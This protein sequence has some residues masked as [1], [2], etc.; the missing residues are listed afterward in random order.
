M[1]PQVAN[2]TVGL[3]TPIGPAGAPPTGL[4]K[5]R[6]PPRSAE[7]PVGPL[8]R[9]HRATGQGP[10]TPV[11]IQ[12]APCPRRGSRLLGESQSPKCCRRTSRRLAAR[13]APAASSTPESA[14]RPA[15][16]P[17]NLSKSIAA[18]RWEFLVAR[19]LFRFSGD[20]ASLDRKS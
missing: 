6:T 15:G 8:G 1:L 19:E 20:A 13:C 17:D 4:W 18:G 3:G 12:R 7:R 10:R 14:T 9:Q 2:T 16:L 11:M 5:L